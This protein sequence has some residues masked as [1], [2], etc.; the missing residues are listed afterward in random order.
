MTLKMTESFRP[1]ADTLV[2]GLEHLEVNLDALPGWGQIYD[3]LRLIANIV[4]HGEG[5]SE[6]Q[7][8]KIRPDLFETQF[9]R[10]LQ[11]TG[12]TLRFSDTPLPIESPLAGEGFYV[13]QEDLNDYCDAAEGFLRSIER[14][15]LDRE[16]ERYP[17]SAPRWVP[18]SES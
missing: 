6:E 15:F 4:K 16:R 3:E 9:E 1:E 2:L 8:R 7:L 17:K 12:Q 18:Q 14:H 10:Q 13:I 5:R 11:K